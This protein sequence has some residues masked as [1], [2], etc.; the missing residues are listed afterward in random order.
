MI[1]VLTNLSFKSRI[2]L[3]F[4]TLIA[5]MIFIISVSL[6]QFSRTQTIAGELQ[7]TSLPLAVLSAD[8]AHDIV[9]I[10]N[11]LTD[12]SATHNPDGLK[13]AEQIAQ[14]FNMDM[15]MFR[16]R[17]DVT[18]AQLKH[19]ESVETSF[20]QFYSVGKHMASVFMSQ[21]IEAG[22]LVMVDFDQSVVDM[23]K[24]IADFKNRQLDETTQ[25][26]GKLVSTNLQSARNL[27]WISFLL[28]VIALSIAIY[29]TRYLSKL[30]G[31]DPIYAAGIAKEIA[32][33]NF[34][35][36]IRLEPGDT[37]SLLH[38]M[39]MM[40]GSIQAFVAAQSEIAKKH[41]EGWI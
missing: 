9:V 2:F 38:A 41:A 4:C 19:M 28:I 26:L 11:D 33:G 40:Q 12:V 6:V 15:K 18:P 5:M 20:K 8:M 22:N 3:G 24:Q 23:N 25:T 35:R 27:M 37:S 30:L 17:N 29:L 16:E 39:K 32:K 10:Q 31:I 36:D 13:H 7:T 34:S 21:G 1:K 14:D